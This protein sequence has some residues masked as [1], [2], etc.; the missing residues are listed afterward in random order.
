MQITHQDL[1]N[2]AAFKRKAE[3]YSELLVFLRAQ[4][5]CGERIMRETGIAGG[6]MASK[7]E[8][9]AAKIVDTEA[10]WMNEIEGYLEHVMIVKDVIDTLED[11]EMR[12]V[13]VAYYIDGQ[14]WAEVAKSQYMGRSTAME[15]RD[16][17]LRILGIE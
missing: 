4:A 8:N 17:A 5:E 3:Y 10:L 11:V 16:K 7:V 14:T 9:T 12:G 2:C 15:K 1:R 6:L 13:L